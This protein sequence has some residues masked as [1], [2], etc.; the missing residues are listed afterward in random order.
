[1]IG[2]KKYNIEIEMPS[3]FVKNADRKKKQL[4]KC[5]LKFYLAKL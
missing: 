1:M 3:I 5:L 2:T 4:H